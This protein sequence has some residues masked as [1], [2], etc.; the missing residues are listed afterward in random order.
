[1]GFLRKF[2]PRLSAIASSRNGSADFLFRRFDHR[3][4]ASLHDIT[5]ALERDQERNREQTNCQEDT[6]GDQIPNRR[7]SAQFIPQMRF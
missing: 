1:M 2:N 7:S 4:L 5:Y 6:K 3:H